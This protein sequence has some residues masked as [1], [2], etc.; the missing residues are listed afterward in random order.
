MCLICDRIKMIENGANPYFVKELQT[1][2]VV[3]GDHRNFAGYTLL[4]CKRHETELFH[5]DK[6]F[7]AAFMAETVTVAHAVKNAFH[8]KKNER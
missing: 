1:G 7:S 5:L 8:A 6:E 4:L 2:Y 3:P